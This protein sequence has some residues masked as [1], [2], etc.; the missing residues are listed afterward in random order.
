MPSRNAPEISKNG[1]VLVY[2]FGSLGDTLVA[3]PAL[4]AVRRNFPQAE[5]IVLHDTQSAGIVRASQVIPDELCDGYLSYEN[6][7][8]RKNKIS[9]YYRLWSKLRKESFDAVVYL[10]ISERPA[11]S[12]RR[13]KL[14]FR[15][16]GIRRLIGFHSFAKEDLYPVDGHGHP[17]LTEHEAVRKLKRLELDYLKIA[18]ED[19]RLPLLDFSLEE[20]QKIKNWLAARRKKNAARLI[21]IA[22]GCKSEANL[23]ALDNFVELGRKLSETEDCELVI[24]GGKIERELGEQLISAWGEGINAA[25][26]LTVRE[27]GVLL[28]LCDLYVGLN[29]GTTHLAAA[30]GTPCLGIYG[31][32]NNPGQWYPLGG[33]HTIVF[34]PV[35]CAGCH[36]FVCPFE[37][38]P[39]MKK[40]PVEAV[41]QNLQKMMHADQSGS[42]EREIEIVSV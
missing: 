17:A 1:K 39:C 32:H 5:L 31:E 9:A 14:F 4:R 12:V 2:L 26:E 20:I 13:D 40:I 36:L 42:A 41:W 21:A 3:I 23:W 24:V 6:Q 8:G 30:V 16:C 19:L 34:H 7:T 15:A 11:R 10:V 29:T 33:G 18:E 28:S 38:H 35:E 25:G 37:N 27:S 22:P